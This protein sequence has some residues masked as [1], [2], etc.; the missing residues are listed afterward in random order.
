MQHI[1]LS[2]QL[3]K[4]AQRRA[5]E[6]GFQSVDEY[7]AEMIETDVGIS[8]ENFDHFFTPQI[9]AELDQ[10]QAEIKAG[11]KTYTQ[12]EIDEHFRRKS[13]AWRETQEK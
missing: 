8:T 6:V 4:Q 9:I 7:V 12:D 3:Y 10:I 13:Q 5:S 1:Q 2:D 11:G